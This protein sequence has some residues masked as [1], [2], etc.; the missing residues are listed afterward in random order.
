MKV[1]STDLNDELLVLGYIFKRFKLAWSCLDAG[2]YAY[3]NKNK[4]RDPPRD[5]HGRV[6]LGYLGLPA[7]CAA[8]RG[9][10]SIALDPS[11]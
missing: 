3:E 10:H 1:I 9:H 7:I 6:T 11:V 8:I 2:T 4:L 5:I